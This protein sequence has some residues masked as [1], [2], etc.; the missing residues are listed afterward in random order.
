MSTT[1]LKARWHA[2]RLAQDAIAGAGSRKSVAEAT[3]R[4]ESTVSS[5]VTERYHP[6][7]YELLVALIE[8]PGTTG[9]A[10]AE[11]CLEAVELHEVFSASQE[12]LVNRGLFLIPESHRA[13]L[14]KGEA[15]L[16]GPVEWAVA[17]QKSRDVD[18]ELAIIVLV[19]W[20]HFNVDL[21][22]LY[23]ERK[24]AA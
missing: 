12:V 5:D 20:Q 7:A 18:G 10:F 3:G 9:R 1:R 16:M 13:D 11:A 6:K 23:I 15:R 19:L 21:R 8:S 4:S 24:R 22:Q 14:E 17:L 2:R